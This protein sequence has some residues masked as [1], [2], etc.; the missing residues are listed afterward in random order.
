MLITST[1]NLLIFDTLNP[2]ASSS[3]A[4]LPALLSSFINPTTSI[5]A[6]YHKDTPCPA[7]SQD[8]YSPAPLA[9][10]RY[11]A[12]TIFTTRA[13]HHVL[14]RTKARERSRIEPSFGLE[15]GIEGIVQGVGANGREG[16]AL[17]MEH[18]RKSGSRVREWYFLP[19]LKAAADAGNDGTVRKREMVVLLE[20]YP[21]YRGPEK[22]E[23]HEVSLMRAVQLAPHMLLRID[24]REINRKR[25]QHSSSG[26]QSGSGKTER[27]SCYRTL[28]RRRVAGKAAGSCMIWV[29][30]MTL[31]KRRTRSEISLLLEDAANRNNQE[32]RTTVAAKVVT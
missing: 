31:M 17:E 28:M 16:V 20:D 2:L 18:R 25:A 6:V 19:A 5:L 22:D 11:L 21:E 26:Y 7:W 9:L 14:A 27:A 4:T 23:N 1:G 8:P 3:P 12:T 32:S 15:E 29:A 30:K 24:D 13:L 10:L